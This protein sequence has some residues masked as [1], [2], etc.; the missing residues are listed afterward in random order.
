[1]TLRGLDFKIKITATNKYQKQKGA[2]RT[3]Q[4]TDM[5]TYVCTAFQQN[6][7]R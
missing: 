3:K 7:S 5:C 4:F 1:M 2:K 6:C